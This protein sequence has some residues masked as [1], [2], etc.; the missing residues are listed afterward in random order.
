MYDRPLRLGMLAPIAWRVPPRHYG[1]WEQVVA[2]LTEGLV[3]AGV[4]VSLFATANSITSAK[5]SAVV[6]SPYEET[7]GMDAKV[8]EGLHLAHAFGQAGA[9]DLLHNHYDFLPLTYASLVATPTLTTIH[10]FSNEAILPVYRAYDGRA[11]YVSISDADRHP[12]LTYL[13]TIH[14]GID[15][16]AFTF[17]PRPGDYLLFFGRIH[18]DKGTVDAIRV[19]RASGLPLVIAGIVQD[20]AYFRDKVEPHLG[21]TIRYVGPAGPEDRD[22]LLGGALGLLHLIGFEEPFGLS[23]VEAMAC[24][25]P[26]LAYPRGSMPELIAPGTSGFLVQDETEALA[27]VARLRALDR[28]AVRAHAERFSAARMVEAYLRAYQLILRGAGSP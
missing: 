18:P 20:R 17:Q 28:K 24:G 7:P 6:P 1:P 15:L 12:D 23:V 11:H 25:T 16:A 22:R 10:G 19:A 26:V 14:H 21:E 13:A 8:W 3:A 27:A 5:L 4:D 2:L 9:F